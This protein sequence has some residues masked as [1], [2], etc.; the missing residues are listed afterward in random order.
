MMEKNIK[1]TAGKEAEVKDKELTEEDIDEQQMEY[2]D[3]QEYIDSL[4]D[5]MIKHNDGKADITSHTVNG[6]VKLSY[7]GD[8]TGGITSMGHIILALS[9]KTNV[10][11]DIISSASWKYALRLK[12]AEDDGSMHTDRKDRPP[13][14]EIPEGTDA[15]LWE[16]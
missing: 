3:F 12:K 4:V 6:S 5:D 10:P 11:I 1:D 16:D 14:E 13:I 9:R 7:S 15:S 2:I 8:V